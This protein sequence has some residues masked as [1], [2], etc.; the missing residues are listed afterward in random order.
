MNSQA[1]R[2]MRR[3]GVIATLDTQAEAIGALDARL[4]LLAEVQARHETAINELRGKHGVLA[5][6]L[7]EL[8]TV[9]HTL[10]EVCS[11]VSRQQAETESHCRALRAELATRWAA[12]RGF[13]G[14]L[15]WLLTGL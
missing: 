2:T 11:R 6:H 4:N 15:K 9:Q 13:L 12:D 5:A 7:V 10:V 3:H 1:A 8:E 14:R